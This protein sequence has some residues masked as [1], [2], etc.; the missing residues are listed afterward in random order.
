MRRVMVGFHQDE[1]GD[2]VAD[3]RPSTPSMSGIGRRSRSGPGWWRSSGRAAQVGSELDCPPVRP[4]RVARGAPGG[5]HG[6]PLRRRHGA[7]AAL[8]R[9][10][11]VAERTWGRLRVDEGSVLFSLA[12]DPPLNL[13]VAAGGEQP[14]PPGMDH[15]LTVDGPVRWWSSSSSSEPAGQTG[16]G[17]EQDPT[18]LGRRVDTEAPHRLGIIRHSLEP[19][20][21]IDRDPG[22]STCGSATRVPSGDSHRGSSH[23]T[24]RTKPRHTS[25]SPP[26]PRNPTCVSVRAVHKRSS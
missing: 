17:V 18:Q 7:R 10:H 19:L 13:Q 20:G 23:R 11:R 12:G 6:R 4:G 16:S 14:M 26:Y 9:Q 1:D 22:P 21:Q 5:P 8:R 15:A 3:C 2:W 25:L 24:D